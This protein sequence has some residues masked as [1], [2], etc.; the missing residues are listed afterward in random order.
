LIVGVGVFGAGLA[1][2]RTGSFLKCIDFALVALE[3]GILVLE[4][5]G[6]AI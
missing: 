3:A 5:T 6:N 1:R 2:F 4:L